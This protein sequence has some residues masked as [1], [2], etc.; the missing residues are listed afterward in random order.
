MYGAGSIGCYVGGRLVAGGADVVLVGR[1][2]QAA[3]VAGHG[4]RLTDWQGTDLAV[5]PGGV[6]FETSPKGADG[7][8]LVLVCDGPMERQAAVVAARSARIAW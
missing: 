7:A 5:P 8:G 2:R 1:E 6:R 3:E 4:L